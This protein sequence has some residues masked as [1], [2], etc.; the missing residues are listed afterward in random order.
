M[1]AKQKRGALGE[2]EF[3][4]GVIRAA[5][6]RHLLLVSAPLPGTLRQRV[7]SFM[8]V[9]S[10]REGVRGRVNNFARAEGVGFSA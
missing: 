6:P 5:H 4:K 9:P 10:V 1:R 7:T 3:K 2:S 8:W